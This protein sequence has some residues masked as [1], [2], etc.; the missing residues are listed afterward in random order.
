MARMTVREKVAQLFGVWVG[1]DSA[2]GDVAPHQHELAVIASDW[3]ELIRDGIGQLTRAFG[4]VPVEPLAGARAVAR[5]QRQIMQAGRFGIPAV[6]HEECLTGLAAWQATVYPS[7]L[8]W[9]ASFDPQLV[10][11]MGARIGRTMRRLG[12]HQGLAPVLDVARDLRWGRVEETIGEDPYLVGTI[13]SAYVRGVESAGIVATLKHFVGYSASRAG[14]NLAPVSIGP[15]ERAD[16]LLPPFEMALRAGVR[17]VMNAYTDMDGMPA[18]SDPGILTDLLRGT[19][20][21]TGTVVADYFAITFLQTLHNVA[22]SEAQ[23]A[24]LALRAGIDVELPTVKCFGQPLLDAVESGEVEPALIDRALERVLRQKCELGLLDAHWSPQPAALEEGDGEIDDAESRALARQLAQRSIVLLRNEGGAL[25][26]AP[27]RRIA[28]VGP[29]ADEAGALMGCYSFPLHVGVHHPDVPMGVEVP[30]VLAAL[31]EDPAGYQVTYAQGVPVLGGDE[32]GIAEA[33]RAAREAEVCV[34]VLGDKAGL[35]GAG[36]SGEG[37]DATDLR[38]PGRQE[39]LLEA[40]LETGTP[41]VLVLLV[42]RP[43]ELSRQADRLAAVVCGFFPGEEGAH[44][45][46]DVL[47]GRVNPSGRLPVSF[48]AAGVNQPWTY[49]AAPLGHGGGV[50]NIEQSALYPFGHGLSYAPVT[51]VEA[52]QGGGLWPTDGTYRLSVSLRNDSPLPASEVVQVYL[53]DPVA[54]VARPVQKLIAAPRVDLEPGAARTVTIDLHADLTA[55]TG[56]DGLRQVDPGEVE[57]RV[58][59]SS[60]DIR[61]TVSVTMTGARREVGFDRVMEPVVTVADGIGGVDGAAALGNG[62]LSAR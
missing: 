29:R 40:L 5:T 41:V 22:G 15:R 46:A 43:Y 17:S 52:G 7:P 58:G 23:A 48:P 6:V 20:G 57:L 33:V 34:V 27:G 18:A 37:C 42:G 24:A 30:T 8:C 16:V 10:E 14:R 45:L 12:V 36:T 13:G 21:F 2:G 47:S 28:V 25:P 31:R 50:S 49:L 9:G 56:R 32:E 60:A 61:R 53:H 38:L 51:W 4:T 35:F 26:L 1:I 44:A 55:Y 54:D 3:D 59:A 11:R 39:Q 19:Y 62:S